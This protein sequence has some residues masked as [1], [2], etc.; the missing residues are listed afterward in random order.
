MNRI[1][2]LRRPPSSLI[3]VVEC[4]GILLTL[5]KVYRKSKF[6]APL[7]SNYD[8]TL[9]NLD[10]DFYEKLKILSEIESSDIDNDIAADFYN[11]ILEPGVDYEDA[12]NVGGLVI[13]E[14]FNAIFVV[15]MKL[16]GD[17]HRLP[18][19][20]PN[21]LA[22]VDGT[23]ASYVALD[24]AQHVSKH[25]ILH[26]LI[27]S[28]KQ[29][30]LTFLEND[31]KR[32]CKSH[33]KLPDFKYAVHSPMSSLNQSFL[34]TCEPPNFSTTD[35]SE[36][37][38]LEN[39]CGK[40][41]AETIVLPY[42]ESC[43]SFQFL[44]KDSY[45]HWAV[46]SYPGDVILTQNT[47]YVRP[48]TEVSCSRT[49]IVYID[50]AHE[51][52]VTLLKALKYFRTGDCIV[53]VAIHPTRDPQGD[54]REL[55]F[56]FG[57]RQQWIKTEAERQQVEANKVG[58]NDEL[59][60]KFCSEMDEL[61]RKSFLNGRVRIEHAAA[62]QSGAQILCSVARQENAQGIMMRLQGNEG[63]VNECLFD[64]PFSLFLLK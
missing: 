51:S 13:R 4:V 36:K 6:K 54:T 45:H 53:L 38:V 14:L 58:W 34:D 30:V 57:E 33:Y 32:R 8:T 40:T 43:G 7:P 25:G 62:R 59:I 2:Q 31:V 9:D 47:S 37:G 48:F 35:F 56:D 18:I 49:F 20:N 23:R 41:G 29:N 26:I 17:S 46:W 64:Q 39:Y 19:N 22:M 63:A 52:H 27:N 16:R 15:L 5:P 21:V 10:D 60:E 11:K 24:T 50:T 12:V 3:K 42:A 55:R 44:S 1:K 61:I 28:D